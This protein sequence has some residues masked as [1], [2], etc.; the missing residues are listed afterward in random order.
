MF[1]LLQDPSTFANCTLV[2]TV[3]GRLRF[4]L[5]R[6]WGGGGGGG[7]GF[8]WASAL[9]SKVEELFQGRKLP[10]FRLASCNHVGSS[11]N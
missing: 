3:S 2:G 7:G 6:A 9:A 10:K 4:K 8:I 11:L 1:E 5:L